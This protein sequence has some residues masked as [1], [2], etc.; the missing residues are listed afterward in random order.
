MRAQN[1]VIAGDYEK[2]EVHI[3]GG[4]PFLSTGFSKRLFINGTTVKTYEVLNDE[5]QNPYPPA[6]RVGS[7][8]ER[9]S[10]R[11][12]WL[13]EACREKRK[14]YIKSLSNLKTERKACWK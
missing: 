10:G 8:E 7:S 5:H 12:A 3:K 6:L 1:R 13:R 14:A 9:F 11:S 4:K 2:S